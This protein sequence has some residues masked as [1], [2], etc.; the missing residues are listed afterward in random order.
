VRR[1]VAKMTGLS[2]AQVARLSGGYLAKGEVQPRVYQR[3]K[4]AA[5]YT[6]A[7]I[8]LLA[9]VDRAYGTLSG[10]ATRR[11]LE[12]RGQAM[13]LPE[14][15]FV[16]AERRGDVSVPGKSGENLD[17]RKLV[18]KIGARQNRDKI[19]ARLSFHLIIAR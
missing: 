1:Y 11:I 19:G 4:F 15:T 9:Y 7:D 10:P 16:S 3:R 12:N 17:N 2:R 13:S 14:R 5:R 6:S 18:D 8:D